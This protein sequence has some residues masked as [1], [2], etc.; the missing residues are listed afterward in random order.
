MS[1]ALAITVL[2]AF[3]ASLVE[4]V[5][6]LTIVLAVG[7]SRSWRSAILGTLGGIAF[8]VVLIAVFGGAL[9]HAPRDLVRIIVGTLLLL[10]GMRWLRKA[11]LRAAG[12][13][14]LHDESAA[15]ARERAQLGSAAPTRGPDWLGISTA[16]NAVV[17]EGLEV[18]FIVLAFGVSGGALAA[19]SLGAAL[20]LIAVVALGVAI[21]RPLSRVPENALK[22]AVGIMLAAF[23]TFW[24]AQ[25][26]GAQWFGDDVALPALVAVYGLAAWLGV[27]IVRRAAR[28]A[29]T[30]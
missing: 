7:V 21:H 26:F 30:A 14:A 18:V 4:C 10:F 15:F 23:G 19:A 28:V 16:F 9:L 1:S 17:L 25:G 3:A 8:L 20:A 2:A 27:A 22:F 6:A 13:M 11:T 12:A 29:R 24:T 5:E